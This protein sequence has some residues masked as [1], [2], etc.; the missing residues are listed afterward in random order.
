VEATGPAGPIPSSVG[1]L[2]IRPDSTPLVVGRHLRVEVR[3][4]DAS[5]APIDVG[6][7]EI[8]STNTSVAQVINTIAVPI[9][10]PPGPVVNEVLATFD[11]TSAGS[12]AIRARIGILS[13]SLVISVAAAPSTVT[14][15]VR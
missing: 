11:L 1:T 5:G 2:T 9:S 15:V 4:V 7:A 12:T 6:Q 8:T 14:A 13:D 10:S 3:G